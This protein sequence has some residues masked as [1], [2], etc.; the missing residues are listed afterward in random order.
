MVF[1][2]RGE[3]V[4]AGH[5]SERSAFQWDL[6]TLAKAARERLGF[7]NDVA[8]RHCFEFF[9]EFGKI[10]EAEDL[11]RALQK[12]GTSGECVLKVWEHPHH[13]K[14]RD[15]KT[16]ELAL[17]RR[18]EAIEASVKKVEREAD[19]KVEDSKKMFLSL[20]SKIERRINDELQPTIE[21]LCRDRTQMQREARA[22][23]EKL[24]SIN[25]QELREM[26]EKSQ[27]LREEIR[28]A[29]KR[30]DRVDNEWS[31]EKVNFR[32]DINRTQQELKELQRY[33]QGKIDVCIEADAD[34]RREQ[35][36]ANSRAQLM[37]DDVKLLSEE[38]QALI[39]RCSGALEESEQLRTL[40]GSVR[41]DNA[42]VRNE[43]GQVVARVH[44]LEGAATEKWEGFS[45]GVVYFRHWHSAAKGPDVQFSSDFLFATGRG[46][47]AQTGVVI[48][49]TEGLIIA[50]GPCR[51]FGTPGT[52]SSYY[53]VEV[54][55]ITAA[56]A[57]A[58]GLYAGISVQ[59]AEE[60]AAHPKLEFDGWLIGGPSRALICRAGS[61]G[62]EDSDPGRL[63][64]T[65][66]PGLSEAISDAAEAAKMLRVALPPRPRGDWRE[67]E[68]TWNADTLRMGDRIGV[69]FRCH[70]DGGARLRILVNGEVKVTH[71]FI[72]APPAE[73]VGF[74]T[75]V[76]RLAG[77]GKSVKL[78]PG[79]IPPAKALAE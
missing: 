45:P 60:I 33:M 61:A 16:E 66:A 58:G 79:L 74:L 23:Q 42:H 40:I 24:A 72:D 17:K 3:R 34:L 68:S 25:V 32:N 49:N 44:C 41:E 76:L 12:A 65:F 75:P 51:R 78:L 70:R 36:L 71:E 14:I 28:S 11:S 46:F 18:C 2:Y 63:P 13:V 10:D 62:M 29:V 20:I 8:H 73:A 59:S 57:G 67:I 30:V 31:T 7:S 64:D 39:Q 77:T 37:A 69:L 21:G 38:L 35:Q 22:V 55:E 1:D 50:D 4:I 9:D 47:L 27:V 52:F 56:P 19:I 6:D 43:C 48:G 26:T 54:D 5:G 15:L 53:E